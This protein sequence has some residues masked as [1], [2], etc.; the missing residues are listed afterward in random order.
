MA[1]YDVIV[2]GAG[3]NGLVAAAYLAKAGRKVLVLE[4]RDVAGGQLANEAWAE[5]FGLDPLHAGGGLRP[6]IARELGLARDAGDRSAPYVSLLPD[7]GRLALRADAAA[8]DA[9]RPYST[10]DAERWPEFIAFMDAAAAFLDAAYRTPMPRL[11]TPH[12]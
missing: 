5:G 3:H 10:R 2:I 4:R 1:A 11:P 8:R 12:P 9:I 6:D 7:G